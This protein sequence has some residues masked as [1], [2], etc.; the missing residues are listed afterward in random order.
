MIGLVIVAHANIARE[1]LHAV[2]HVVGPQSLIEA[3]DIVADTDVDEAR[4]NL[5][6]VIARC[7]AGHGVLVATDM[8]GGTPCNL[9]L[10]C[11]ER[12]KIEVVSGFNLP[13]LIK[14][15]KLRGEIEDV[16][17]LARQVQ[18]TGRYHMHLA[19]DLLEAQ[20]RHA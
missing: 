14:A 18:E 9:A 15:S 1:M 16:L 13:L 2:E 7:D 12:G 17:K 8:F 20:R 3:V 11:L 10:S 19:S 4:T 5:R 6:R